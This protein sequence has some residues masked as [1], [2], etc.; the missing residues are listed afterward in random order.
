MNHGSYNFNDR[1]VAAP[2]TVPNSRSRIQMAFVPSMNSFFVFGGYGKN[3]AARGY[4]ADLW[5]FNCTSA[6]WTFV[7][8]TT[9]FDTIGVYGPTGVPSPTIK[10]GGRES[11]SLIYHPFTHSLYVFGGRGRTIDL[12]SGIEDDSP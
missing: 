5:M 11:A 4:L 7:L 6:M 3:S 9:E 12:N 2:N 10:P 8:G 1:G